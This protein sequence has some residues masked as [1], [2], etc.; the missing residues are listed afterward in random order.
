M[1]LGCPVQLGVDSPGTQRCEFEQE[2]L[3]LVEIQIYY[4]VTENDVWVRS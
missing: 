2:H 4:E 3:T 1:I